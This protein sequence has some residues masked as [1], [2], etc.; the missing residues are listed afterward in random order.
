MRTYLIIAL[1][2]FLASARTVAQ[3]PTDV[4]K[5]D[6]AVYCEHTY[7]QAG[8]TAELYIKLKTGM[9]CGAFGTDIDFP[10]GVKVTGYSSCSYSD[11]VPVARY[12]GSAWRQLFA[13][14]LVKGNL[15]P[16]NTDQ[17]LVKLTL[18]VDA[19]VPTGDYLLRF[20]NVEIASHNG[21]AG[22]AK[23]PGDIY[24][25]FT[26][27]QEPVYDPG[28]SAT[29]TPMA[30]KEGLT[31]DANNPQQ[32]T[33]LTLSIANAKNLEKVSFRMTL[34]QG[35]TVG[36]HSKKGKKYPDPYYA[37]DEAFE[38]EDTPECT[39]N[40]DGTYSVV[41]QTHVD[42]GNTAL[43]RIPLV[44]TDIVADG[45][46][47][48]TLSEVT[49]QTAPEV[50]KGHVYRA[51]PFTASLVVNRADTRQLD[52]R[53][54]KGLQGV[55]INVADNPNVI[56]LARAGQ[57]TNDHNVVVDGVCDNLVLTDKMPFVAPSA[58]VARQASYVRTDAPEWGTV[59]LPFAVSSNDQ[60][61]YY[62]LAEV[63]GL[64]DTE[65]MMV[66]SPVE[67]IEPNTPAVY[68]LLAEGENL[69]AKSTDASVPVVSGGL[70][71]Q[72]ADGTW[73]LKGVYEETRVDEATTPDYYYI[74]AGKF[75]HVNDYFVLDPFRAY[76]EFTPAPGQVKY[77]RLGISDDMPS[78]VE[79]VLTEGNIPARV[80][81]IDGIVRPYGQQ[82]RGILIINGKKYIK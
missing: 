59:C 38:S 2:L 28:F 64:S 43:V 75:Y 67:R 17:E 41:A 5:M 14:M 3:E 23:R 11:M 21:A 51:R 7:A 50:E 31:H 55:T 57:V 65:G 72:M 69:Q 46:H 81:G 66:F 73:C 42:A 29:F 32:S 24:C 63:K 52:L 34:P 30:V 76:F 82:Q 61:Q 54:A 4:S 60:V 49:M 13:D 56:I 62:T 1:A 18:S 27:Q 47:D 22:T 6:Y 16:A 40:S 48:V 37:W 70:H 39:L 33:W 78:G 45:C 74:K 58:F 20:H 10:E 15:V 19:S 79:S 77:L 26:V 68:R 36:T 12:V 44:T 35:M 9:V 53:E 80:Y 8:S 25:R 71:K